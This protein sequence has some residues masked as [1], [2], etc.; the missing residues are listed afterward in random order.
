[1]I[2]QASLPWKRPHAVAMPGRDVVDILVV[3]DDESMRELLR[4]HLSN[5]GYRVRVA[6]DAIAAGRALLASPPDL[7]ITDI[8]MPHM[9]GLELVSVMRD[10][11]SLPRIPV[12][13]L[14]AR[15]DLHEDLPL[16]AYVTKP[17]HLDHLLAVV[18]K[19]VERGADAGA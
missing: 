15:H 9:S 14:T 6:E 3:D 19:A 10:D 13:F 16:D 5:A 11:A 8:E 4:L 7:L 17:V 2:T 18:R 1:M 12:V